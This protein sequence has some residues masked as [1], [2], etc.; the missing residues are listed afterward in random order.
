FT[1]LRPDQIAG[2]TRS[3]QRTTQRVSLRACPPWRSSPTLEQSMALRYA[4]TPTRRLLLPDHTP[5]VSRGNSLCNSPGMSGWRSAM[6]PA[7]G[8]TIRTVIRQT[9]RG[10]NSSMV[11]IG[12]LGRNGEY[13][14]RLPHLIPHLP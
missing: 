12:A 7:L 11:T 8:F 3:P 9:Y 14:T 2:T 10:K 13:T 6:G 4:E 5:P 1:R